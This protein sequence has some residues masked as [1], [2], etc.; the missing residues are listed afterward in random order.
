MTYDSARD[1]SDHIAVVRKYMQRVKEELSY[2][3]LV[4][5]A[6]KLESPEKDAFDIL[7]PRLKG[8]TYGSDEYK[9]SLAELKPA[10]DHHY[11][12]NSH[13]PEYYENG[14][15]GMSLLDLIEMVCDWKAASERH[16]DGDYQK[17]LEINKKRFGISDQLYD[18]LL[19]TA[20]ELD[21]IE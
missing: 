11:Q 15:N 19:N 21:F 12:S 7:P 10:L 13:H 18:I 1:T 20:R 14:I 3:A 2:R 17:S 5:D 16:A 6:S 9:A 4:H 8:L